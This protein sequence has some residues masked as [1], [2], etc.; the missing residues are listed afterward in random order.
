MTDNIFKLIIATIAA[1]AVIHLQAMAI[2]VIVLIF[3]MV[4]DYITGITVAWI[5]KTLSSRIGIIGIVKK[6]FYLVTIAVGTGADFIITKGLCEVGV[7][8]DS[9]CAVSM[10]VTIWL[11]I[12]ELISILEN[13]ARVNKEAMPPFIRKLLER[14]KNA[15][16]EK[17]E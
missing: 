5:D 12:N 16:E 14:L 7:T 3:F 17:V 1:D 8:C 13:V 10:I 11:I 15:V 2:P 4:L 6:V 9:T